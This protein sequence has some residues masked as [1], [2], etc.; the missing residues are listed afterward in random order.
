M[1]IEL[2]EQEADALRTVL[3]DAVRDLSHEIA[4]TDNALF[5][6]GLRA[7]RDLLQ[8]ARVKLGD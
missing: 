4:D 8:A 6:E 2:D 3:D 7:R 5:R 1:Q